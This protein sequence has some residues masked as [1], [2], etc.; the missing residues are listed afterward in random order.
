MTD[1]L[2]LDSDF[3]HRF[4]TLSVDLLCCLGFDGHFRHLNP[5]WESTLGYTLEEL[6][7]RPFIDFVHPEDRERTLEQNRGV[8]AGEK[9]SGFENRYVCRDGSHRW[10]LWNAT[11]DLERGLVYSVARDVTD[12]R[13]V[14]EER[15]RLVDELRT[16]LAEVK[17]LRELLP[18][19]SYC[20]RVRGDEDYWHT[21][22]AYIA[23]HTN[24]RF[25]HAICPPCYEREVAP[26]LSPDEVRDG[27]HEANG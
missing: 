24:T 27:A 11:P 12:R 13:R 8:R 10:L 17:T 21:V 25:S 15:D 6:R 2:V 23:M 9:A 1:T 4:F 5:A 18:I 3:H 22:E 14:E 16:A 19:C 26:Q 20:R 7:A